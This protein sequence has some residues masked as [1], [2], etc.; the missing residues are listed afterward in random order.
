MATAGSVIKRA[1]RLLGQLDSGATPTTD[2]Y[3][4]GLE[5][6]NDLVDSW[7]ND[8]LL[9]FSYQTESLT[10]ADGDSS[11]TIGASGDLNTTRPVEILEA[12]VIS[13][14]TSYPV[15]II[16]EAE[17]AA[18]PDKD[19]EGDFPTRLL[20]RP[21]MASSQATVIV[22]PV[23][24]AANTLK[25]TTRVVVSSFAAT[26]TTVTLPPGWNRALATNLAVEWAPEFEVTPAGSVL[27]AAVESLALIKR[28]N[29]MAR[30]RQATTELGVLFGARSGNII[31]DI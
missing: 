26:S 9:C 22:H 4:D 7:N 1:M 31:S 20:F 13:G 25:I 6:L 27:K 24:S 10:L 8:Q 2:E 14:T 12:Y 11:Y 21:T 23:P 16:N 5:V 19:S 17:Y 3:T 18:I 28:T 30:P 15:K 29:I